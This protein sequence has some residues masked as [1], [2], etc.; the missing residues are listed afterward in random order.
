[1]YTQNL[2]DQI[3]YDEKKFVAKVLVN[4]PGYR[5]ILLN[6]R[7]GQSMPE[8]SANEMVTV[9]AISG[10]ITFY[11][12]Q[13]PTELRAG[14]VLW[15]DAGKPHRLEAH[16]DSSLLVVRA[17]NAPS[18]ESEEELDLRQVPGPQRHPLIFAKFDGLPV[19]GSIVLV[20][21]HDPVPLNRQMESMR[22]GQLDW[23]YIV[24][25]PDIFRIRIRRIA[26]PTGAESSPV[27]GNIVA[28]IRSS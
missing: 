8:H 22:S 12:G 24:R 15:I 27:P 23:E 3:E 6:F 13:S 9:Y 19:G 5:L 4:Q 2:R 18:I 16:E 17:G 28:G 20:N 21:D 26:P 11:E 7:S 1:M 10:H 14:E 25:G